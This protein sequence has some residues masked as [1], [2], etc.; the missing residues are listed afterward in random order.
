MPLREFRDADGIEWRVWD[1]TPLAGAVYD[2][3]LKAGWLTFESA[4][5]RRRLA[6]IPAGWGEMSP[7]QLEAICRAA[8]TVRR[9]ASTL[10]RDPDA[11]EGPRDDRPR[12]GPERK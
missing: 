8:E 3:R 9:G 4:Q 6:P 2:E 1:T 5:T 10:T 7:E 11:P 12:N